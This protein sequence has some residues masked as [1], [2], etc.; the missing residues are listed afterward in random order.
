MA[1]VSPLFDCE[2]QSDL[3]IELGDCD[4]QVASLSLKILSEMNAESAV[5][6]VPG[7]IE[8][9]QSAVE[10]ILI[11]G[12]THS[13]AANSGLFLKSKVELPKVRRTSDRNGFPLAPHVRFPV[14]GT[15]D[16]AICFSSA[17]F[18]RSQLSKPENQSKTVSATNP[19]H[20]D[21]LLCILPLDIKQ[22]LESGE[23]LEFLPH[24]S[25]TEKVE[26]YGKDVSMYTLLL[27]HQSCI[28][29]KVSLSG[30]HSN[31]EF[32]VKWSNVRRKSKMATT[33]ARYILWAKD[34]LKTALRFKDALANEPKYTWMPLSE[35]ALKFPDEIPDAAVV[36]TSHQSLTNPV[37]HI[38]GGRVYR[39]CKHY[40]CNT[41][42]S[43]AELLFERFE[44][45]REKR[46]AVLEK[47][48]AELKTQRAELRAELET[49]QSERRAQLAIERGDLQKRRGDLLEQLLSQS[50]REKV[51][52]KEELRRI[53]EE[54]ANHGKNL[55]GRDANLA[56][57]K[58]KLESIDA[59]LA[60]HA[61]NL[62]KIN[63][64]LD[65]HA[66]DK[67]L[68]QPL[69]PHPL[70]GWK[71]QA[72]FL[73]IPF[74]GPT[75]EDVLETTSATPKRVKALLQ[76][77]LTSSLL[78]LEEA[79][80]AHLDIRSRNICMKES[81]AAWNNAILI[82]FDYC[83]DYSQSNSNPMDD[84]I[85]QYPPE[86]YVHANT[87]VW[88]VGYLLLELGVCG[89]GWKKLENQAAVEK[90]VIQM[91][92]GNNQK[93][94]KTQSSGMIAEYLELAEKCLKVK[95]GDRLSFTQMKEI[96]DAWSV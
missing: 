34:F 32:S 58:K 30:F 68:H 52:V 87:D 60:N 33:I 17:K 22:F 9:V 41:K 47:R 44:K 40:L 66:L 53:N 8:K 70:T 18:D 62:V 42:D 90:W 14:D 16:C 88:M 73:S 26:L 23:R 1:Q 91:A 64:K 5:H 71:F 94:A 67:H 2:Y 36:A 49:Q 24:L 10:R 46:Q 31:G 95:P 48:Q 81:T 54:L 74:Y 59:E 78:H 76:S 7:E 86:Q 80:F 92:A 55:D 84:S 93:K 4:S 85:P 50:K 28:L 29:V 89:E 15:A 21:F 13:G 35:Y 77:L 51:A 43:S 61:E 3:T 83:V 45:I 82:D 75:L 20:K 96:V 27:T 79:R 11:S 39:L 72:P 12:L 38:P 37:L 65:N 25:D 69:H 63:A 19:R 56:L 6:E 57:H